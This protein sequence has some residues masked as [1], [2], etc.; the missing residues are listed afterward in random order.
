MSDHSDLSKTPQPIAPAAPAGGFAKWAAIAALGIA[1]VGGIGVAGAFGET[2]RVLA[3]A[4]DGHGGWHGRQGGGFDGPGLFRMLDRLDLTDDQEDKIWDIADGVRRDSR[5]LMR[6][7]RGTRL[8]LATLLGA[9]T[10]DPAAV[11]ALRA[12]RMGDVDEMSKKL[13]SGLVAAAEVLTPEQRAKLLEE[14]KDHQ[15]KNR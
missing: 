3:A 9:S 4:W 7:L 10:V 8:E 2:P 5:P 6:D 12:K 14:I 1:A 15:P 13:T 11:E